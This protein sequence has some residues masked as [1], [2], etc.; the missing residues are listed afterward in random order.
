MIPEDVIDQIRQATDIV[1]IIGQYLRL[2]KRGRSN[3]VAVCPFHTEKTAS[4]NVNVDRQ[5]YH[6]FGCGKGGNVFTFLMEH[7]KLSFVDAVR[8]LAKKANIAIPED[9]QSDHRREELERLSYANHTAMEFFQKTLHSSAYSRIL[10]DYLR[11]RRQ[12]TDESITALG[13]GLAGSDWD[14]L[15]KYAN[16][17]D[18]SN[19][20]LVKAGL[21]LK[22]ETK[23]NYF[24]RFRHR[25]M[26]PIFNLSGK[27][28]A[29]GGRTLKK[30]EPAKYI[31]S[32]E[33]PLYSKSNVLYGLNWAREAIRDTG[34][35]LVVEGYFD[36]ISLRQAG[37]ENVVASSGT[38][39]TPQQARLLSRFADEVLLFFDA[40]SAGQ[41]AALRSVDVLYDAGMEVRVVTAPEGEDPDSI[42]RADGAEAIGTLCDEAVDYI[43]FRVRNLHTSGLG[44]IAKE[45][46]IKE[47]AGVGSRIGDGTRR[48]EFQEKATAALRIEW[49]TIAKSMELASTAPDTS[50]PKHR[51]HRAD[52]FDLLSLLFA[53]GEDLDGIIEQVSP[54]DFDSRQLARLYAAIVQQYRDRGVVDAAKMTADSKDQEF[55]S[56]VTE[57]ASKSWQPDVIT[58]SLKTLLASIKE[59]GRRRIRARIHK[60]LEEAEAAGDHERA[61]MLMREYKLYSDSEQS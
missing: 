7:E 22:S 8:I 41:R 52:E 33:T 18:I 14:G 23:G 20:D 51:A 40:D 26:I 57:V 17:K 56:L 16:S 1:Q 60:E 54:D 11:G 42:A 27:P 59:A 15:I 50:A 24:D 6:C 31:N 49:G 10:D 53:A 21:A 58:L 45:K 2:K 61:E 9:R 5:I 37:I 32:P 25:L 44:I 38:A 39:F 19:D 43:T 55:V 46:L 36:V 3:W 47:V 12:I 28:I 48:L 13:L 29:F 4:F 34:R 30:G 35:A